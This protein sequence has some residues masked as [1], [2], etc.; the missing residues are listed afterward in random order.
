AHVVHYRERSAGSR[1]SSGDIPADAVQSARVLHVTGITAALSPTAWSALHH[2]IKLARDAGVLISVDVNH[3]APLWPTPEE[4]RES[5]TGLAR[6][7]DVLFVNQDE[8]QLI[9][10]II[11]TIR[12]L[13]VTRGVKGASSTVAGM[14]YDAPAAPVSVV[15]SSGVGAAFV[16]GYLSALLEGQHPTSRLRRGAALA[17]FTVTSHSHWQGLP[18][19]PELPPVIHP[20]AS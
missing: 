4:A 14:R 6:N 7:A 12:E 18:T 15:D 17:A 1:L 10:P 11:G 13:V 8:L 9:Q 3:R 16:A 5:L 20:P 19:R 2:A